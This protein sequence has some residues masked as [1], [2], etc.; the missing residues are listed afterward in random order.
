MKDFIKTVTTSITKLV[1]PALEK[2]MIDI[3]I[4]IILCLL[5]PYLIFLSKQYNF[6]AIFIENPDLITLSTLE[7]LIPIILYPVGLILFYKEKRSGWIILIGLLLYQVF[8]VILILNM[9][10]QMT[11]NSYDVGPFSELMDSIYPKKGYVFYIMQLVI[12]LAIWFYLNKRKFRNY[13]KINKQTFYATNILSILF[14]LA[15]WRLIG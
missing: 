14:V 1:N 15:L 10:I 2:N 6:L 3:K 5:I 4:Y 9:E 11:I 7:I 13:F 12:G 8:N